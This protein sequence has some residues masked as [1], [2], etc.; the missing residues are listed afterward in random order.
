MRK[1]FGIIGMVTTLAAPAQAQAGVLG[2]TGSLNTS[3]S[4]V[5]PEIAPGSGTAS[6]SGTNLSSLSIPATAF[7]AVSLSNPVNVTSLAGVKAKN[8]K[9]AA[10]TF[11]G[12]PFG[13]KMGIHGAQ[14]FCLSGTIPGGCAGHPL[15]NLTVPFTMN[16]TRGI[17]LGGGAFTFFY[18]Q[19]KNQVH[20]TVNGHPWVA[21]RAS[22]PASGGFPAVVR[23]G[24]IHGPASGGAATAGQ[25]SGIVQ[26]VTPVL[27]STNLGH[28]ER[29]PVF[30][31]MTVHFVPV[32][33]P[34]TLVLLS[35]GVLALGVLGRRRMSK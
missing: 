22:I 11:T 27:L 23:T 24:F 33:E 5:T 15:L 21:G 10:G 9:N 28:I 35:S 30:E 19:G 31:I 20:L 32:P 7:S 14:V 18:T 16:G 29:I 4:S 12:P 3:V 26:L 13:G 34:R 17:G 6:I 1:V 25:A 2:F 8:V